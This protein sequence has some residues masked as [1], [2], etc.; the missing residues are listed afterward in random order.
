MIDS[1][2]AFIALLKSDTAL[3][4]EVG[5]R[6]RSNPPGLNPKLD[7]DTATG[8]PLKSIGVQ[9]VGGNMLWAS[10]QIMPMFY[11]TAYAA[12]SNDA[13]NILAKVYPVLYDSDGRP[14]GNRMISNK[15]FLYWAMM[16]TLPSP[17]IEPQSSW[18]V[19]YTTIRA[20]FD[21]V[22]GA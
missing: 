14:I 12:T 3:S 20:K 13:A 18:P 6:I 9:Q 22:R 7:F 2:A 15:W 16:E 10:R 19:A 21:A 4:T 8:K 11:L 5:G 17:N 1:L